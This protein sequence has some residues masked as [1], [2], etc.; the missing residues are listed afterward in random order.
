[1][2]ISLIVIFVFASTPSMSASV[3]D[4]KVVVTNG[5]TDVTDIQFVHCRTREENMVSWEDALLE[6][7]TQARS[8]KTAKT[9][10]P[11]HFRIDECLDEKNYVI[12]RMLCNH[13]WN[14]NT[15]YIYK[16][17]MTAEEMKHGWEEN[18]GLEA[19]LYFCVATI[20][21]NAEYLFNVAIVLYNLFV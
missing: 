10:L 21:F 3:K 16:H 8:C 18:T 11:L 13:C 5:I 17:Q 9:G 15:I 1:M 4:H 19:K 14:N 12:W 2:K 7:C 6:K 20:Y